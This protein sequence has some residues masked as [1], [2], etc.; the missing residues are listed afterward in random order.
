LAAAV[1][2]SDGTAIAQTPRPASSFVA[3]RVDDRHAMAVIAEVADQADSVDGSQPAARFGFEYRDADPAIVAAVPKGVF[4]V[5]QWTVHLAPGRRVTATAGRI[6]H[7]NAACTGLA[8]MLL[9]IDPADQQ[10]YAARPEKY[11][12]VDP[13]D[14][15]RTAPSPPPS[16]LPPSA[17]PPI[18]RTRLERLLHDL[19]KRELPA[20][21]NEAASEIDRL[22]ESEVAYQRTWA[23]ERREL[24]AGLEAGKARLEYDV[25]AFDLERNGPPRYFVRAEW[26][27]NGR[28]AFGAALWIK[29]GDAP[30]IVDQ[31]LSTARWLRMFEF[32][33]KLSPELY[34]LVLNVFDRD[35]DGWGEVLMA[36]GGYES[37]RLELIALTP[38]GFT[39]TGISYAYGC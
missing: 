16:A 12:V 25:Q 11:F 28:P 13:G 4:A 15:M 32:Q 7:G 6:V 26:A 19:L 24:D 22:A 23:L 9:R 20:V 17:L 38:S 29:G 21:R 27:V 8:G 5:K 39:T 1:T 30:S 31:D 35:G 14:G 3:F 36:R 18:D 33:G 2:L 37:N 34:G 10:S